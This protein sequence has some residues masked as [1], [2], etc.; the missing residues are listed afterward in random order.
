MAVEKQS[1]ELTATRAVI[2]AIPMTDLAGFAPSPDLA[3][4][5]IEARDWLGYLLLFPHQSLRAAFL[6]VLA[7]LDGE[8][9]EVYWSILGHVWSAAEAPGIEE[10]V[11]WRAL[12]ADPR[13]KRECLMGVDDKRA[14]ERL[15]EIVQVHRGAGR[16]DFARGLSWTLDYQEAAWFAGYARTALRRS[17]A[18]HHLAA[19]DAQEPCVAHGWV[20]RGD[21][22][23]LLSGIHTSAQAEIIALPESVEIT[24]IERLPRTMQVGGSG[25]EIASRHGRPLSPGG[26]ARR[27]RSAR[28]ELRRRMTLRRAS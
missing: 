27:G 4:R 11:D 10:D 15:P 13:P 20:A 12:F 1:G 22:I 2:D 23:A 28:S 25:E 18:P 3:M 9:P 21:V 14:Y 5:R 8:P 24:T 6:K 7:E 16:P 26:A 17:R 19:A